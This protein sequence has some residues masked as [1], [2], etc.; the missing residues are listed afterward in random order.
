MEKFVGRNQELKELNDLLA[1]KNALIAVYGLRRIGKTTLLLEWAHQSRLP[2]VHWQARLETAGGTR[3]RLAN[4][5]WRWAYATPTTP[6]PRP[7]E[8]QDWEILFREWVRLIDERTNPQTP[9]IAIF[10]EFPFAIS[11]DPSLPSHLQAAW[12][13]LLKSRPVVLVLSGSHIG[14]MVDLANANAPLFGRFTAKFP[15]TQMPYATIQDF[16]PNFDAIDRV[17][18]YAVLG[19][20]PAYLERF[21]TNRSARANIKAH[22]FD[23]TGFFRNEPGQ[24]IA[25]FTRDAGRY[26]AVMRAIADGKHTVKEIA[27][28]ARLT[29]SDL[30]PYLKRLRALQLIERRAPALLQPRQR[31]S[32][33][34]GR[35]HLSHAY[36]RFWY[37]F[38]EPNLEAIEQGLTEAVWQNIT[39]QFNSFVGAGTFEELCREWV[40]L[41][42]QQRQLPF[43]PEHVGS[44][45]NVKA[46]VDVVAVNFRHK[47]VLLGEC[48]WTQT[49]VD[50][51]IVRELTTQKA[52]LVLPENWQCYFAFF[53]RSGFTDDA[54][55][56]IERIGAIAVTLDQLDH[57]LRQAFEAQIVASNA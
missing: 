13:L 37:R 33:T 54:K 48:K 56:E 31:E 2:I 27:L 1:K 26:E 45:W 49:K 43:A 40:R 17:E 47:Q 23:R 9:L 41:K 5:I 20:M 29:H 30:T 15:V 42:A 22:L 55:Q 25:E 32:S 10:D 8:F 14:M 38:V 34:R 11:S 36:L 4:A 6:N 44:E 28:S 3:Q 7:P 16:L 53:S 18:T 21:Q 39:E 46:Q 52:P 35:Y 50:A 12:D 51:A 19:G 57:D 24:L